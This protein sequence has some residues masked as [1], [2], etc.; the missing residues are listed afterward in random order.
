MEEGSGGTM[1]IITSS[2]ESN[3]KEHGTLGLKH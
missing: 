2:G 1:K 3:G